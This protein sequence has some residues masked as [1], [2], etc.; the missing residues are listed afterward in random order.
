MTE[1][2][3]LASRGRISDTIQDG[4]PLGAASFDTDPGGCRMGAVKRHLP[5]RDL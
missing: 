4:L 3:R 2:A 5:V 1:A